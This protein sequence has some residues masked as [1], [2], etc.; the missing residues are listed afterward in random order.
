MRKYYILKKDN[1]YFISTRRWI[2]NTK[3]INVMILF[4]NGIFFYSL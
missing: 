1:K 4:K 2:L 3:Q